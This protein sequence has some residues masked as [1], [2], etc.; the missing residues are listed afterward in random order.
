MVD[1]AVM[2]PPVGLLA[3]RASNPYPYFHWL[4]DNAPAFPERKRDGR[5]VWYLSRYDDVRTLL[6]DERLSKNPDLV[7]GY[8]PGPAGLNKHLVHADPPEHTRL[9]RLVNT[10]FAPRRIAALEPFVLRTAEQLLDRVD[11]DHGVDLIEEFALPLTFTLIC[12][13]LGVPPH[14]NTPATRT[15]FTNTVVPTGRRTDDQLRAFSHRTRRT[16][17]TSP[18]W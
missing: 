5:T 6:T 15:M 10:A 2:S 14:M 18:R 9:R 4:R 3:R 12:T 8:R 13:I 11:P 17:T 1:T 16:Q 7:P